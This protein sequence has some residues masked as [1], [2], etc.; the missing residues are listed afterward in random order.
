MP[1]E[2]TKIL[3]F[4]KHQ[5]SAKAPFIIYADLGCTIEKTDACKHNPE[6]SS[7]TKLTEHIPS[8][9]SMSTISLKI[10]Q[11][12]DDVYRGK[13]YMKKFC[14]SLREHAVKVINFKNKKLKLL[15]K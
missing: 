7:T 14:Q 11:N 15:T 10:I 8:G 12:K 1:S 13:H 4:N 3:E 6:N 5:K 2:D 9:F